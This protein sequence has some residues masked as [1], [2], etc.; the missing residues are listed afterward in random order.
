MK[1]INVL[2]IPADWD[3]PVK[4]TGIEPTLERFQPL[5]GGFIQE[6][7]GEGVCGFINEGG[8]YAG[9]AKNHRATSFGD[10][11]KMIDPEDYFAG[12]VVLFADDGHGNA[13]DVPPSVREQIEKITGQPIS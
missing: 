7:S 6:V 2:I 13:T 9:L 11:V 10:K 8:K 3:L 1:S 5:V 12:D 4:S